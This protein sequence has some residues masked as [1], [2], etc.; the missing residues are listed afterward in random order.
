VAR[1]SYGED[2]LREVR[3]G[4]SWIHIGGL[5]GLR[6]G[7]PMA[8]AAASIALFEV[9]QARF[10]VYLGAQMIVFPFRAPWRLEGAR[11]FGPHRKRTDS[12][13]HFVFSTHV[14]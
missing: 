9:A 11:C 14:V 10:G 13:R 5:Q 6:M 7:R 8:I 3:G 4:G 12:L 2:E 1:M